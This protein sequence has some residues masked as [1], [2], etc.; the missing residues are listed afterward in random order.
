MKK[1]SCLIS[2]ISML[3][4]CGNSDNKLPQECR[5]IFATMDAIQLKME[6]NKYVPSSM[7]A[8][9]KRQNTEF[10]SNFK[11]GLKKADYEKQ[12]MVC[13]PIGKIL[14]DQLEQLNNAKSEAEVKQI[15]AGL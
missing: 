4:A 9:Y 11:I 6:T 2:I 5:D 1:I 3:M 15:F 12:I 7:A 8:A 14:K 10:I 13:K